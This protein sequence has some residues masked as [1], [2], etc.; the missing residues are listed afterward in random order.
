MSE[1]TKKTI[2]KPAAVEEKPEV[3]EAAPKAVAAKAEPKKAAA[4]KKAAP[5][6]AAPKAE[7]KS[8]AAK[9]EP[10]KAAAPRKAAPKK[11]GS[12]KSQVIIQSP[13]GGEITEK[14]ILAKVG[15]VDAVYVRVDHNKAYW[16][17]G[18]EYGAVDLW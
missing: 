16:V 3:K 17:K 10:K 5:K 9:A 14:E 4:P 13:Y 11:A 2:A 15:E 8:A 18:E 6:K 12:K 7:A 1:T